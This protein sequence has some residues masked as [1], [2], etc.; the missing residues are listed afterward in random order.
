MNYIIDVPASGLDVIFGSAYPSLR[1]SIDQKC[2]FIQSMI[3]GVAKKPGEERNRVS[4][5]PLRGLIKKYRVDIL[6][7]KD[8]GC[9]YE[10]ACGVEKYI[11]TFPIPR[12][13]LVPAFLIRFLRKG[14]PV[15]SYDVGPME[16]AEVVAWLVE[17]CKA[18]D[19]QIY[20]KYGHNFNIGF[21]NTEASTMFKLMFG[22]RC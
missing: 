22:D 19:Y 6:V 16:V 5:S 11:N 7:Y 2:S 3:Q 4:V 10:C 21:K 1:L 8:E 9:G 12:M 13:S 18:S 14:Y 15:D 20:S 17:N